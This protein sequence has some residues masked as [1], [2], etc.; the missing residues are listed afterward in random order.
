[1]TVDLGVFL[2]TMT[3]PGIPMPDVVSAGR[4]A[5]DLGFESVWVVDQL[6]AGTGA[7][8]LES[9]VVL[10]AV[11]EVF[12][13]RLPEVHQG[14]YGALIV[15]VVLFMPGGVMTILRGRG[16]LPRNGRI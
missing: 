10:S 4:H 7:P 1:M 16:I 5:E 6:V 14:V 2:P 9:T 3:P 13:A 15:V 8:L 11:A 12:W